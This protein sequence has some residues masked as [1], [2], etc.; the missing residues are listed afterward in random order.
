MR[1]KGCSI[2]VTRKKIQRYRLRDESRLGILIGQVELDRGRFGQHEASVDQ[3]WDLAGGVEGEKVS[4][5]VLTL[6]EV[7]REHL[8]LQA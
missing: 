2:S 6:Q 5:L 1:H 3:Y 8:V 7:Y 4:L